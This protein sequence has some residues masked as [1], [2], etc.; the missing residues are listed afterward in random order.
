MRMVTS[1][2]LRAAGEE[3][4]R[5]GGELSTKKLKKTPL[6]YSVCVCPYG[7]VNCIVCVGPKVTAAAQRRRQSPPKQIL[8]R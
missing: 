1:R 5:S 2:I 6:A 8:V 7:I 4:R 3:D